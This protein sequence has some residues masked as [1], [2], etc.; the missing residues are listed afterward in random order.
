MYRNDDDDDDVIMSDICLWRMPH[1]LAYSRYFHLIVLHVCKACNS[2]CGRIAFL[3]FVQFQ[4]LFLCTE[5]EWP[6]LAASFVTNLRKRHG[7]TVRFSDD[8]IPFFF[9]QLRQ[10]NN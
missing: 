4:L 6:S 9:S 1:L 2:T 8:T 7:L 10:P 5:S 3:V